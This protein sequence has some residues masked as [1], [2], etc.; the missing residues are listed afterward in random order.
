MDKQKP[1]VVF[2]VGAT[3]SGK[4]GLSIKL[5]KKISAEIIS[6]DSMQIYRG[7]DIGT[8]KVTKEE[9]D[10]VAHHLIDILDPKE[11]FSVSEYKKLCYEKIDEIISRG[12]LPIIV[13]GT[14][15]YINSVVNNMQF[16]NKGSD[17]K[18]D[19]GYRKYL[20]EVL[21][22]EGKEYLYNMLVEKDIESSKNIHM[23]NVKRVMRA[24]EI[25]NDYGLKSNIEKREDL[26]EKNPSPYD[27]FVI[28]LNPPRDIL[29]N[30]INKRVELMVQNGIIEETK[31]LYN[32]KLDKESTC[33][34]A[35]GYKEW[36]GY[37]EGRVS[38]EEC[39]ESLKQSTRRYAK[40]QIT[41]FNKLKCEYKLEDESISDEKIIEIKR[42]IYENK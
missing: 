13:G 34:A 15:L 27:F 35:I 28:Y 32:M 31:W 36:F 8:A 33:M 22:K 14:G 12:N 20:E 39:K 30:R 2:I 9:M 17:D 7:L 5:A 23:N 3:A 25:I 37:I 40:R 1:K 19:K 10:E 41:W 24:L 11:S 42:R 18:Q 26:W 16:D 4:T 21:A 38:L 6:A 29:Y